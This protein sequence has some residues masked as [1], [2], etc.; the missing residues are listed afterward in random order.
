MYPTPIAIVNAIRKN[1][2]NKNN[3]D[4][5]FYCKYVGKII[6]SHVRNDLELIY[7]IFFKKKYY[8]KILI[9]NYIKQYI[10]VMIYS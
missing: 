3:I 5:F 9:Y 4:Q 10:K 6:E 2:V 8:Y 1:E 7:V